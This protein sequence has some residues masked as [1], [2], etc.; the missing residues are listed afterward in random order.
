MIS[1]GD[2]C[3]NSGDNT[4]PICSHGRIITHQLAD[5]NT[6]PAGGGGGGVGGGGAGGGGAGGGRTPGG[7]DGGPA[8]ETT[9]TCNNQN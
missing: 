6:P 9:G 1:T 8:C 5:V 3:N 4:K 7:T 2:V